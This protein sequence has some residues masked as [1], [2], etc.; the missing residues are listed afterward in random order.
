[1]SGKE[2][3]RCWGQHMTPFLMSPAPQELRAYLGQPAKAFLSHRLQSP[4]V[5]SGPGLLGGCRLSEGV[6]ATGGLSHD[7]RRP[8]ALRKGRTKYPESRLLTDHH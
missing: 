7:Q 4:R 1:M 3:G 2:G 8:Q 5:S 6:V